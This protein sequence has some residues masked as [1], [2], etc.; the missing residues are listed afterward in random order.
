MRI[1]DGEQRSLTW[2][3]TS[4]VSLN[5]QIATVLGEAVDNP[6]PPAPWHF[7]VATPPPTCL[8]DG[9][10]SL[11]GGDSRTAL[12]ADRSWPLFQFVVLPRVGQSRGAR[13][14]LPN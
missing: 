2:Y 6:Q 9:R 14:A 12:N 13:I 11:M 5:N 3:K 10:P 8:A 4:Q 1:S 7:D